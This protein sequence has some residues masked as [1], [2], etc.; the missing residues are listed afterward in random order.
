[1]ARDW[2]CQDGVEAA[3]GMNRKFPS[4]FIVGG[5]LS[6]SFGF[7]QPGMLIHSAIFLASGIGMWRKGDPKFR[8][9]VA[10]LQ[11]SL[12]ELSWD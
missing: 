5:V 7:V 4:V 12:K 3:D 10:E 1:M 11:E 9:L 2:S 6:G 8:S